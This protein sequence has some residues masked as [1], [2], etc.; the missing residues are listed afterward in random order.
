MQYVFDGIQEGFRLIVSGDPAIFKIMILSLAVSLAATGL[1]TVCGVPL[2][3]LT[4]LS[5]F[6]GKKTFRIFLTTAMGIPP[7]IIGLMVALLLSRR[8][9]LGTWQLL[10]TPTAMLIAQFVL[11]L[12]IITG[13]VFSQAKLKGP[14][15]VETCKTLGFTF[16]QRLWRLVI[17]LRQTLVLAV[18]TAFGRAISEVGAVML[19]G[20]NIK[21]H[22]R[23]M[24]TYIATQNSMGK[25]ESSIA[26][27]MILLTVALMVNGTVQW[28]TGGDHEHPM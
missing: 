25:Y 12:P 7:V 24:T 9:P 1:A 27:A 10:F 28:L 6:K 13:V 19:V 23:V 5:D 4:G 21:D 8:G 22:T 18:L 11:V 14:K 26:M 16:W 17:E 3:L 15:V 20:G 2:G